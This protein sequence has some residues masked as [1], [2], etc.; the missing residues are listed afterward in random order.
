MWTLIILI[1]AN[2]SENNSL[3]YC[4]RWWKIYGL[5]RSGLSLG[6]LIESFHSSQAAS[7]EPT[8]LCFWGRHLTPCC[9]G[10]VIR[11]ISEKLEMNSSSFGC[12]VINWGKTSANSFKWK[13]STRWDSELSLMWY[14]N[15]AISQLLS[16]GL[17]SHWAV[18]KVCW[19]RRCLWDSGTDSSA[20]ICV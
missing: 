19:R 4:A 15:W 13:E 9:F 7:H 17:Y 2:S 8:P 1:T 11:V 12:A 18:G 6:L 5:V 3:I 10:R 16:H 20:Q 14:R